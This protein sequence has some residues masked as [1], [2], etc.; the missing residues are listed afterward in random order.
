MTTFCLWFA[1][2]VLLGSCGLAYYVSVRAKKSRQMIKP[3]NVLFA[4]VLVTSIALFLPAYWIDL[5]GDAVQWLKAPLLSLYS[6]VRLFAFDSDYD[7]IPALITGDIAPFYTTFATVVVV[8]APMLT[9]SF[10]LSFFDELVSFGRLLTGY[11]A[12]VYIFSELND[13]SLALAED[14]HR[15][16]PDARIVFT[17]VFEASED[18]AFEQQEQARNLGAILFQKDILSVDFT[19]HGPDAPL[20]FFAIAQDED[21]NINHGLRLIEQYGSRKNTNL[22]VF[23]T[24]AECE[25]LLSS[26]HNGAMR[27]R[28]I[29]EVRSLINRILYDEG[30]LLFDPDLPEVDGEKVI[31]AVVVGMGKHG[32]SMMRALT[33]FCQM[34][35]FRPEIHGFDMDE[36]A[37]EKFA[38]RS[39]ELM[40][41]RFNGTTVPGEAHYRIEIHSGVHVETRTFARQI[42][43]LKNASYV[44]VAL[45][46]DALNIRTAMNLRMLFEQCGAKPRIQAI[47]YNSGKCSALQNLKNFKN[48]AYQIEFIGD[49][50]T[51]YTERVI[52]DSEL[53]DDALRRHMRWGQEAEFWSYEYNYRSS[54]AAAIHARAKQR[55]NVPG[56]NKAEEDLTQEER[57][58]LEDLEHR[59]WNAYMRSEGYIYS[60]NPHKSSRNDLGKMHH[61]LIPYAD[62]SEEDK[63]KDSKVASK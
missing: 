45:G 48:Q 25:A 43:E 19:A 27:V 44:L 60:G 37:E 49:L 11:Y 51:S 14:I 15:E 16:K 6:A 61:D 55:Q 8:A 56:A 21:S 4:G 46:D 18:S 57:L 32:T 62:L 38:A 36:L 58:L 28:R 54:V 30:H 17:D 40:D 13:R 23:S 59:R 52:I 22:Y 63:R 47:V 7:M 31:T 20:W 33:W 26:A 41:P 9:F 2:I 42:H 24:G 50:E 29:D 12:P 10:V 1:V 53:E 34:E 35:G 5:E 39:P 3:V